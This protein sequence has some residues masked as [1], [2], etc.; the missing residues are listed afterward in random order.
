MLVWIFRLSEALLKSRSLQVDKIMLGPLRE[1]SPPKC[2]SYAMKTSVMQPS[3]H[4]ATSLHASS[5]LE[6]VS[7]ARFAACPTMIS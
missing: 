1:I 7:S 5:A 2:A 4:V 3:S 6:D